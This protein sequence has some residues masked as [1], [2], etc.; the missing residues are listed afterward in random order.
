L[1]ITPTVTAVKI[2]AITGHQQ[3]ENDLNSADTRC[4]ATAATQWSFSIDK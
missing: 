1:E 3:P 4:A 2:L